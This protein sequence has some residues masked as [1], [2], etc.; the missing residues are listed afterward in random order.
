[1][2]TE[3]VVP[4]PQHF[5]RPSSNSDSSLRVPAILQTFSVT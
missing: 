4:I 1:M 5:D 3:I 2:M